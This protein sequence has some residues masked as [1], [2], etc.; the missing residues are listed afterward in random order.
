MFLEKHLAKKFISF[1]KFIA[2]KTCMLLANPEVNYVKNIGNFNKE[3]MVV[4]HIIDR[5]V[6]ILSG[7]T[8]LMKAILKKQKNV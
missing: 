5:Q 8:I 1:C 7:I 2:N 3:N 6:T 4:Q